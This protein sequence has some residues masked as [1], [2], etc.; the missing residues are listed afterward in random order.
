MFSSRVIGSIS[1]GTLPAAERE[2]RLRR[3]AALL[4]THGTVVSPNAWTSLFLPSDSDT[5]GTAVSEEG[6][7]A[8]YGSAYGQ[9]EGRRFVVDRPIDS[10]RTFHEIP[11][12]S[13]RTAPA[14]IYGG[15]AVFLTRGDEFSAFGD[16]SGLRPL[17]TGGTGDTQVVA[18]HP[19]F[20]AAAGGSIEIDRAHEDFFLIYGFHPFGETVYRGVKQLPANSTAAWRPAGG[21]TVEAVGHPRLPQTSDHRGK[22][23]DELVEELG[24]LLEECTADQLPSTR[25]V[26]VLLGGFDSALV[27]SLA[28]RA[29]KN[30]TTYTY[31]FDDARFNQAHVDDLSRFLGTAHQWV[32][33]TAQAIWPLME[34]FGRL[35]VQPTNWIS[36]VCQTALVGERMRADGI[37]NVLTGDGCDALFMGFPGTFQ[38]ARVFAALPRLPAPVSDALVSVLARPSLERRGGHPYRMLLN[39]ARAT[40]RPM[41]ERAFL[42]FRVLD[43]LSLAQLDRRP[44]PPT[45]H[46]ASDIAASLAAPFAQASLQKAAYISKG[47]VSPSKIKQLGLTDVHGLT[48]HAPY[49]HPKVKAFLAD[50]PDE[51]LRRSNEASLKDIGKGLLVEC[52]TRRGWL[53][54]EVIHQRKMSAVDGPVDRWFQEDLGAVAQQAMQRLP[55]AYD[56]TYLSALSKDTFLARQYKRH[57]GSTGVASDAFSLLLSYS[58]FSELARK[59][60]TAARGG[61]A[62]DAD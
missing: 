15:Y 61:T 42:T 19:A 55:F 58:A 6:H 13:G 48:L 18:T 29:G 56:K 60:S 5:L 41:P 51:L 21:G 35:F 40:R 47:M 49:L 53:P 59:G 9:H 57:L 25:Q 45:E 12:L 4:S 50:V 62:A 39:L 31:L 37:R 1:S 32:P 17:F 28:S 43:E 2:A 10:A 46:A 11:G 23:R 8:F 26:G 30:V 33:I 24:S 3:A 22:S 7:T 54:P 36:Y 52:A 16:P 27:A 38:R 20:A 34:H 14:G 44:P